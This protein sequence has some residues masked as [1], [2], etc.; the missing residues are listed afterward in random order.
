MLK[1][2][3]LMYRICT[4]GGHLRDWNHSITHLIPFVITS[5][6]QIIAVVERTTWTMISSLITGIKTLSIASI[7]DPKLIDTEIR[8]HAHENKF[9]T[10]VFTEWF[11]F[12]CL[13][14][15]GTYRQLQQ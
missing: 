7:T 11:A 12:A 8:V 13:S 10:A 9:G 3:G 15:E 1:E 5:V 2:R 6:T 14:E 4:K